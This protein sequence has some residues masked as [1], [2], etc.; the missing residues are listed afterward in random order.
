VLENSGVSTIYC[1]FAAMCAVAV[2]YVQ[3]NIVETKGK[4][5]EEIERAY[6]A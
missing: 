5:L 6:A 2:V 1:F 4:S 3:T